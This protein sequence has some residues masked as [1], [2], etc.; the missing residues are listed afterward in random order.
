MEYHNL[1][2]THKVLRSNY[3]ALYVNIRKEERLNTDALLIFIS[4]IE[5]KNNILKLIQ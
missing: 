3:T 4:R 5:E 2:E 1:W